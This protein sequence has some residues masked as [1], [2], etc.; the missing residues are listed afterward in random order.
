SACPTIEKETVEKETVEKETVAK[1][2]VEKE[3]E[4]KA[5][6]EKETVEAS[7][8][9]KTDGD[10]VES[11]K[12]A[13]E[14]VAEVSAASGKPETPEET[15]NSGAAGNIEDTSAGNSSAGTTTAVSGDSG[16]S[17]DAGASDDS[18]VSNDAGASNDSSDEAASGDASDSSDENS[19]P[20][21]LD[22]AFSS[23][24]DASDS[25]SAA[26][27]EARKATAT[28]LDADALAAAA[29]A[30]AASEVTSEA[31]AAADSGA[32]VVSNTNADT[33]SLTMKPEDRPE[34]LIDDHG[35]TTITIV[36]NEAEYSIATAVLKTVDLSLISDAELEAIGDPEAELSEAVSESIKTI[37]E[38]VFSPYETAK[39]VELS[40]D[41]NVVLLLS[42]FT[43]ANAED[44]SHVAYAYHPEGSV[45][46]LNGA[47]EATGTESASAQT[48]NI[49][50]RA[51]N[52]NDVTYQVSYVPP[53]TT[54]KIF[55]T[56]YTPALEVG[57]YYFSTP[58]TSGGMFDYN[59]HLSGAKPWGCGVYS[60]GYN[61]NDT[62]KTAGNWTSGYG[63]MKYYHT[64]T[65]KKGSVWT[66]VSPEDSKINGAYYQ[67]L[68]PDMESESGF[69]GGNTAT[70]VAWRDE[71]KEIQRYNLTMGSW[72]REMCNSMAIRLDN[73]NKN[74]GI[75]AEATD[76][77]ATR[78]PKSYI[79]FYGLAAMYKSYRVSVTNP[80]DMEF[81][82]KDGKT[83]SVA[84]QV[85]AK[86]GAQT[87][88]SL[89]ARDVYTN[90]DEDQSNMVFSLDPV[91]VNGSTGFYGRITGYTIEIGK[92]L[93]KEGNNVTVNYPADFI[94]FLKGNHG[95]TK[96]TD[97]ISYDA[98]SVESEIK[99]VN[100]SLNT[101]PFD[102]YFN[103]WIDKVR[104]DNKDKFKDSNN[105]ALVAAGPNGRG[106]YITLSFRPTAA[107]EDVKVRVYG[108]R[109]VGNSE[110][111]N[112]AAVFND[113]KLTAGAD[114]TYHAGDLL[115]LS[116][117]ST[118]ANFVVKGYE[119]SVDGKSFNTITD[120]ANL[121]LKAVNSG[122]YYIRPIVSDALNRIEVRFTSQAE[123]AAVDVLNIVPQS[124]LPDALKG[125]YYLDINPN[126]QDIYKRME[127]VPGKVY[128]IET[129]YDP[130]KSKPSRTANVY[131]TAVTDGM[132]SVT[133]NTQKYYF[134]ARSDKK[135]NIFTVDTKEV[136]ASSIKS[137]NITGTAVT[138]MYPVRQDG[139]GMRETAATGYTLITGASQGAFPNR[140]GSVSYHVN[141]KTS[142]VNDNGTFYL[143][144]VQGQAGDRITVLMD[145]GLYDSQVAEVVLNE[146][147]A[148]SGTVSAGQ[149]QAHYPI[150]APTFVSLTYHYDKPENAD[151]VDLR[152]NQIRCFDDNLKLEAVLD[153]NG[154][155]ISKVVFQIK[156][157]TGAVTTVTGTP[158]SE[159]ASVFTASIDN[160][161]AK[162][163]NGDHIYAY[164]VDKEKKTIGSGSAAID[165]EIVYPSQFTGLTTFVENEIIAPK[166]FDVLNQTPMK[167]DLPVLGAPASAAK[168]GVCSFTR[169]DYP[170]K[171]GYSYVMNLD[172][173]I[174]Q[175]KGTKT[176]KEKL[177][178]H[179]E[180]S[181]KVHSVAAANEIQ[182]I[183]GQ[184]GNDNQR[185]NR[186]N[187]I[188][189]SV[190]D[191]D[192]DDVERDPGGFAN[193]GKAQINETKGKAAITFDV[194]FCLDF[195]FVLDPVTNDYLLASFA[196]TIGA[197]VTASKAIYFVIGYVPVFL[198]F[199][200]QVEVDM[201][202]GAT[203][204]SVKSAIDEGHFN[205][206]AGNVKDM[207]EGENF[208]GGAEVIFIGTIQFG[209][210]LNG[211][212]S[213]K[214]FFSPKVHMSAMSTNNPA[215]KEP[216]GMILGFTGGI[217]LDL[218]VTTVKFD[219]V[220]I[221]GAWGNLKNKKKIEFLGGAVSASS[222]SSS[223]KSASN[224]S[225]TTAKTASLD[226]AE[227][228]LTALEALR[229]V[230]SAFDN[231][232]ITAYADDS[233]PIMLADA[234]D[235]EFIDD[236]YEP[237]Y[238][239][240]YD[241]GADVD[242][243][244][245]DPTKINDDFGDL[246]VVTLLEGAA[247]RTRPRLLELPD[248]RKLLIFIA[249]DGNDKALRSASLY[250]TIGERASN[251]IL[252]DEP[253]RVSV[254]GDGN[255]YTDWFETMPDAAVIDDEQVLIA[256]TE[257]NIEA[258]NITDDN[259]KKVYTDMSL[260]GSILKKNAEGSY[261]MGEKFDICDDYEALHDYDLKFFNYDP[262][263]SVL[264]Y[265]KEDGTTAK[266][267][268]ITYSKMDVTKCNSIVDVTD[269][270]K[271]F[272]TMAY[273]TYDF[274]IEFDPDSPGYETGD[275]ENS[276][277]TS[278]QHFITIKN[279]TL[280]DPLVV[281][282]QS[283][284]ENVNGRNFIV[285]AFTVDLD[286]NDSTSD[287]RELYLDLHDIS[288]EKNQIDYYPIR[289]T[290]DNVSQAK[291]KLS[292]VDGE[293]ILTWLENETIFNVAN[294]S[295]VIYG[296][297][298][299]DNIN[300]LYADDAY[301]K[302]ADG[303]IKTNDKGDPVSNAEW[304][305]Q[306][307]DSMEAVLQAEID[308]FNKVEGSENENTVYDAS[309]M[310]DT[311]YGMLA[312]YDMPHDSKY[313]AD[314]TS[315][316][317]LSISDYVL[318]AD[319]DDLCVFFVAPCDNYEHTGKELYMFRYDRNSSGYDY[320]NDSDETANL[321][322]ESFSGYNVGFSDIA[323]ITDYNS[324]IDD[325]DIF[326]DGEG[327]DTG[328]G[329]APAL[330]LVA[331]FY[332][333]WID[334][335]TGKIQF[336]PNDLIYIGAL[337]EPYVTVD[338][339][340]IRYSGYTKP[341]DEILAEFTV[342][343][344]GIR[345][346]ENIIVDAYIETADGEVVY[347]F[348]NLDS[349]DDPDSRFNLIVGEETK[350]GIY[351]P[352]GQLPS[353][354]G[355][356]LVVACC[357]VDADGN[358]QSEA[359]YTSFD[360][361]YRENV[362]ISGLE[363]TVD[364]NGI[365]TVTGTVT[366]HGN[367]DAAAFDLILSNFTYGSDTDAANDRQYG[368]M[369][370]GG[371]KAG[372]SRPFTF[373]FA[374]AADDF[375]EL[376]RLQ[377]AV[378]A[379][380]SGVDASTG[381]AVVS[382]FESGFYD[383]MP[384]RPVF[385]EVNG[386]IMAIQLNEGSTYQLSAILAPW[387][388]LAGDV[389]YSSSD[390]SIAVVD[391]NG[392]ITAL[393]NGMVTITIYYPGLGITRTITLAVAPGQETP[394]SGGGSSRESTGGSSYGG[395]TGNWYKDDFGF[396]HLTAGGHEYRNEW[397]YAFNPYAVGDQEKYSWF[398]FDEQAHMQTGWFQDVDGNW[399]YLWPI[400]D[401]VMGH[402]LIGWQL[403]DGRWYY[404][405]PRSGGPLG[406]MLRNT[407]TPDGYPV[408][409]DGAWSM[410]IIEKTVDGIK[411]IIKYFT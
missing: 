3:T 287:D 105:N 42:D 357:G 21:F 281:D 289:V 284:T 351:I 222:G 45:F 87:I 400:S 342:K 189:N 373:K 323:Q 372:E 70:F 219:A 76:N 144:A 282:Y 340:S 275:T 149:L 198:N 100:D 288:D 317:T 261:K 260:R 378:D 74:I 306:T 370:F 170:G 196:A 265:T 363:V 16:S 94:S 190:A 277:R 274:G 258:D 366:N 138:K 98:S 137:F 44:G 251:G 60:V 29:T 117:T 62:D 206:Y 213:A 359:I 394:Y 93:W 327:K 330:S 203:F 256:W 78:T 178:D 369:S 17:A 325:F 65:W 160:M 66:Q 201:Y 407:V 307:S 59:L 225:G 262:H 248:G 134:V 35:K 239:E 267:A 83:S 388:E 162:L 241:I 164:I 223:G 318:A 63:L 152:S 143:D 79:R 28:D 67:Y 73:V 244:A 398:H 283:K 33:G 313:L 145:N 114:L 264:E 52:G 23:E 228:D 197:K 119:V 131:R 133:Y 406:S 127:P 86:C 285:N 110:S 172:A 153:L 237:Y 218:L 111:G 309:Y 158:Q 69:G 379:M 167:I 226:T 254:D 321:G 234:S 32:S 295:E 81:K 173:A 122:T 36:R 166:E 273:V 194:L 50:I 230:A 192:H 202:F 183:R 191:A 184:E 68:I 159:G 124:A 204:G 232:N 18:S 231:L 354:E 362:K 139:L 344:E 140:D 390:N 371:L 339:S 106:Y 269:F 97:S 185:E 302:N 148:G 343:N 385:V 356:K 7:A 211:T 297:T 360:L 259:F 57:T 2:T 303:S 116:A 391:E 146:N 387:P 54:G 168:S 320:R 109:G 365:A 102:K 238:V 113:K 51:N 221:D 263:I 151:K 19:D 212:L 49:K 331:D 270:N 8:T 99:K 24:A 126:E 108:A 182:A 30:D 163:H 13:P 130:A 92:D 349:Y 179:R 61:I 243:F 300:K 22:G 299:D 250:Y 156:T 171:T 294:V 37:G 291:P 169:T 375:E 142:A 266:R 216:L 336:S 337:A 121:L 95:E 103:A 311:L 386:G 195:E 147:S 328:T 308:G 165:T 217:E 208:I 15:A 27:S 341:G 411:K 377:L 236:D 209:A 392:K 333:Q 272:T 395:V 381:A 64:T 193:D 34:Y 188:L 286:R 332:E 210:G 347:E 382:S 9:D 12:T 220:T 401:N 348:D 227:D 41:S 5:A 276:V 399:Y 252:W 141:L 402:M 245:D 376:G 107:Y 255:P 383:Y 403:I 96:A 240:D 408:G 246:S 71:W 322:D 247:E 101:I 39:T 367:A 335:D 175:T 187:Q 53:A 82:S 355:A 312:D 253:K 352:T 296:L 314:E 72:P 389:I 242:Q 128:S 115:D 14:N 88:T 305:K 55:D 304:Y 410:T 129:V 350:F 48:F 123:K 393:K 301:E 409:D 200:A 397:V 89:Y 207:L 136:A 380:R 214:G 112:N 205:A 298:Y 235:E 120:T 338:E 43:A 229:S 84:M 125:H 224:S 132:S 353:L 161:L 91:D 177:D 405:N 384:G 26:A 10:K 40:L 290:N 150:N 118:N 249:N 292:K 293:I 135:D 186:V 104:T 199:K 346:A 46:Y 279:E 257:A 345:N 310:A 1:E 404:F 6:A 396:W 358:P 154:R 324:V 25:A 90:M 176:T 157:V 47:A 174:Y 38:I 278:D 368:T 85:S 31:D 271:N 215:V 364:E 319:G 268:Y 315:E 56:R 233:S 180:F 361:P 316:S 20:V 280:K 334:E 77:T 75:T 155:K 329:Y 11:T 326:I 374:V 58:N 80:R 4:E 181:S